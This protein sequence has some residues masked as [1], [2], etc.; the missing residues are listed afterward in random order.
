MYMYFSS[1]CLP[2]TPPHPHTHT[3]ALILKS[4]F[5]HRYC[6]IYLGRIEKKPN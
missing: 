1:V 5:T 4:Y 2:L 3:Y 6:I